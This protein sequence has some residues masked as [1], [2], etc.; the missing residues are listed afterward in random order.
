MDRRQALEQL[1]VVRPDGNDLSDPDLA[2]AVT[3][4]DADPVARQEFDRRLEFDAKIAAAMR[5]V[6][7]VQVPA[8]FK[9][10]LVA[11][12]AANETA[13]ADVPDTHPVKPT[14]RRSRRK[15]L[16]AAL[17]LSAAAVIAVALM[18]G[19]TT[20][21][22]DAITANA[23]CDYD[24]VYGEATG[25]YANAISPPTVKLNALL[26][27]RLGKPPAIAWP[28]KLHPLDGNTK[29]T[30]AVYAGKSGRT[31]WV[32]VVTPREQ[33]TDAPGFQ[34]GG[35]I[36]GMRTPTVA[37]GGWEDADHVYVLFVSGSQRKFNQ[38]KSELQGS[39][40]A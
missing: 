23:P 13:T 12:A 38:V 15:L 37:Y 11:M 9:A 29:P 30:S 2:D 8:D 7:P 3:A 28:S 5:D 25:S 4:L 22:Y 24:A 35:T 14:S 18:P 40:I 16:V 34:A 21:S 6:E 32:L 10:K 20:V 36:G 39:P 19:T 31:T 1:E 27:R 26:K 17:S 33:V